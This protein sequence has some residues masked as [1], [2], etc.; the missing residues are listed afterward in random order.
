MPTPRKRQ[1]SIIRGFQEEAVRSSRSGRSAASDEPRSSRSARTASDSSSPRESVRR[2]A[3]VDKPSPREDARTAR[4]NANER[5]RATRGPSPRES[6]RANNRTTGARTAEPSP[7]ESARN[8]RS[9]SASRASLQKQTISQWRLWGVRAVAVVMVLG[10]VLGFAFFLRPTTS[11]LENRT[12]TTFP[13][14]TPETFL[15][16]TFTS[17]VSLWYA[18]TFPLREQLVQANLS[19]KNLYGVKPQEQLIGGNRTSDELPPE[20]VRTE[21]AA[22][23]ERPQNVSAP[24]ARQRAADIENQITDG[25]Y[26]DTNAGA[27]YTLYYFDQGAT[28][29]YVDVINDAADL[30]EGKA[31]VYSIIL[32]TNAGIMLDDETLARLGVAN[33]EQA[34]DYYYSLMN[35]NVIPVETFDALKAHDDEYLYFRT[36]HHWQQLGAYYVYESFC[37]T[38]GIEPAPFF[39]WEELSFPNYYGEYQPAEDNGFEADTLYARIPQGTNEMEFWEYDTR[40]NTHDYG[41]VVADLSG[42]DS[43][44][45]KYNCFVCTNRPLSHIHNPAVTDG[46]SCLIIKDSFGNPFTAVMVD[47]YEDIYTFDFRFCNQSLVS[48]VEKY[49]IQDVIFENVLMF[50]GTYDCSELLSTIVYPDKHIDIEGADSAKMTLGVDGETVA[51]VKANTS[52]G[53]AAS[54]SSGESSSDVASNSG[55]ASPEE[56]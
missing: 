16:G 56:V 31:E 33:Q 49:G 15:D 8:A 23:R 47:S 3:R 7:R 4:E 35:D 51:E 17:D 21:T 11:E 27:V 28:E 25:M 53:S 9:S 32:P 44:A 10:C 40:E 29:A 55:E 6:A 43:D 41:P 5:V 42:P 22:T 2:K 20:G 34:I 24:E 50:A 54:A 39:E 36:D 46:S 30:L 19:L 1:S 14:I 26:V 37:K 13:T 18:D 38:K 45:N 12:L 52:A 48:F